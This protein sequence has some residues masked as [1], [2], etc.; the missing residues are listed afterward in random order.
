[1]AKDVAKIVLKAA[2]E[3]KPFP[4]GIYENVLTK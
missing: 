3:P 2:D 1:M 4:T